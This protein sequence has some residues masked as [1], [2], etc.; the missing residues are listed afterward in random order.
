MSVS[1][2][3]DWTI[4]GLLPKYGLMW[5]T[6]S[7]LLAMLGQMEPSLV[8]PPDT[9]DLLQGLVLVRILQ[10]CRLGKKF[11]MDFL[12]TFCLY[13]LLTLKSLVSKNC[14]YSNNECYFTRPDCQGP[15]A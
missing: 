12:K 13:V 3:L 10:F 2:G 8:R 11:E 9:E 15:S 4:C 1:G 7:Y 5:H 6:L 14:E